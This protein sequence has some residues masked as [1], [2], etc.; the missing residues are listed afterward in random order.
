[1]RSLFEKVEHEIRE[2]VEGIQAESIEEGDGSYPT[3][4]INA[5]TPSTTVLFWYVECWY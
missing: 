3:V 5:P 2:Q 1:M 4:F